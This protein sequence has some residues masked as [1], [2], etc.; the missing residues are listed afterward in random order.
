MSA[1]INLK[2]WKYRQ[3]KDG[4]FPI[5]IRIT[6]NRKSSWMSTNV[7]V[8]A[9]EWDEFKGRVRPGHPNSARLNA[10]LKQVELKYQNDIIEIENKNLQIG[11]RG[12][13]Q[14]L[15][16]NDSSLFMLVAKELIASYKMQGK[17][18]YHSRSV[19]ITNKFKDY[20][21]S[22]TFTFQDIDIRL[23]ISYQTYMIDK[24]QNKPSTI[25]RDIKFI[26]TVFLYAQRMEYIPLDINP[27]LKFKFLNAVSERGFLT[28]EEI[29]LIEKSDCANT[30]YL[31]K[32]K[33]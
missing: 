10:Y 12:I 5:Y 30:A 18:A 2:L 15:L 33:D 26:K 17:I 28:P 22:E 4:L 29:V 3:K 24:L 14:K 11:I 6:K 31:Q 19:S 16:G 9:K 25:N 8:K 23:L 32:A 20:M 1:T 21:H 7:S 13:K 27:F